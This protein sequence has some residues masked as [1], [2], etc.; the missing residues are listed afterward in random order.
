MLG[1]HPREVVIHSGGED[2]FLA[3]TAVYLRVERNGMTTLY[4]FEGSAIV[5]GSGHEVHVEE[6]QWTMFGPGLPPQPPAP[7]DPQ[8]PTGPDGE[9]EIPAPK[10]LDPDSPRLDLPKAALP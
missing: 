7:I 8:E 2:I 5:G 3:G 6:G 9:P 4:V 10:Q 1:R